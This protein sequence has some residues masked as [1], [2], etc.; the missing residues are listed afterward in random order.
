MSRYALCLVVCLT[1]GLAPFRPEPHI[2]EKIRWIASGMEGMRLID[3]IDLALHGA[4]WCV[5]AVMLILDVA[6]IMKPYK[7]EGQDHEKNFP[8]T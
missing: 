8:G 2:V 3:W 7:K 4:P 6:K 5:L 1:L